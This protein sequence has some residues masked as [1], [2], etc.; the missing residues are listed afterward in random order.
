MPSNPDYI[1][2]IPFLTR[3]KLFNSHVI[4]HNSH[5]NLFL[6]NQLPNVRSLIVVCFHKIQTIAQCTDIYSVI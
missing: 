3:I 1:T 6:F 5:L 4:K 2:K